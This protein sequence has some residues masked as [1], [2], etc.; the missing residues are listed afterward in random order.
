MR[1][2]AMVLFF[3]SLLWLL[4]GCSA[5]K[6]VQQYS[7]LEDIPYDSQTTQ[8]RPESRPTPPSPTPL[9]AD[10]PEAPAVAPK[11]ETL[12]V[13][14]TA[15]SFIGTP[16]RYGGMGRQGM[17]CSGLVYTSFR[18]ID[19]T[20][21]RSTREMAKMGREIKRKRIAPGD[22][23]FF[24]AKGG[25]RIDHVGLVTKV[26]GDATFF[27]HSTSSAGVRID[28]L[29]DPYWEPRFRKAVTP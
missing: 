26:E 15:E 11:D 8:D 13:I 9:P 21:P 4:T 29:E 27:I 25:N 6:K 18:S 5:K 12:Q 1:F 7:Y 23:I 20:L 24:A 28:Q 10:R 3:G 2:S 19:R 17:D 16:Y 22:L 14:R